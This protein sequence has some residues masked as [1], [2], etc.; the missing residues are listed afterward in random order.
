MPPKQY[1]SKPAPGAEPDPDLVSTEG[2][3]FTLDDVVFTC[4]GELDGQDM[5]DLAVPMADATEGF[6]DPEALAAV[7][8]FYRQVMGEETYRQFT[9]HRR[10]HRTPQA[11]VADIMMDL[12]QEITARP[13]GKPSPSP[14][15]P[16]TTGPSSPAGSPSPALVQARVMHSPAGPAVDPEGIIPPEMAEA[17]DVVLAAPPPPGLEHPDPMAG[18]H[19]TINLGDPART[20]VE[21]AAN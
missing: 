10:R 1:S 3:S 15:G 12:V 7:G 14:A 20:K 11:V 4:H 9:G 6:F 13:P 19:R 21:P 2:I 17:V 16:P 18:M 5:I 8:R